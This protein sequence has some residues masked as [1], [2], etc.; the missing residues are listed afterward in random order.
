MITVHNREIGYELILA[1]LSAVLSIVPF[2]YFWYKHGKPRLT[3]W[4]KF[5][6]FLYLILNYYFI[7]DQ[8]DSKDVGIYGLIYINTQFVYQTLLVIFIGLVTINV[9]DLFFLIFNID[10]RKTIADFKM[11]YNYKIRNKNFFIISSFVFVFLM[12]LLL[13]MGVIGYGADDEAATGSYSFLIQII[14]SIA[15]LFYLSYFILKY[16]VKIQSK[17][18]NL[19]F[20]I[21]IVLYILYGLIAGM[22][23]ILI[24]GLVLFFIP[25]LE[26]GGRLPLKVII[27]A[28]IFLMLL[29]PLNSNYRELINNNTNMSRVAALQIAAYKTV[30]LDFNKGVSSSRS[31]YFDRISMFSY[32][33]FAVEHEKQW[34][35]YKNAERFAY[36]PFT[37]IPRYFIPNKPAEENGIKFQE[38]IIRNSNNSP[39]P[40]LYG[41]AYLEGGIYYVVFHLVLLSI[42]LNII[43]F[44]LRKGTIFYFIL[45]T[46]MVIKSIIIEQ[47][48]YF[49]I[50]TL[51]QILIIYYLFSKLFFLKMNNI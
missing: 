21:Y 48:V 40:T 23:G 29:Y 39:T 45:Y 6:T 3:D 37:L 14:N 36:L 35:N 10:K 17:K 50:A 41:W 26:S 31:S 32:L 22:K 11:K 5:S 43:Q 33:L 34:Y 28:T 8:L 12:Y 16:L 42:T 4:V 19:A 24:F 44:Y 30:E 9:V 7:A 46:N 27:P 2:T 49:F 51:F 1:F 15:P 18:F 25:F 20:K 38:M 13:G 47:D